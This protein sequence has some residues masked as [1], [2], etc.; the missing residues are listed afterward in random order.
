M[1]IANI[2]EFRKKAITYLKE[3]ESVLITRHGK[4]TGFLYPLKDV[5]TI[6]ENIQKEVSNILL[7]SKTD[8][9]KHSLLKGLKKVLKIKTVNVSDINALQKEWGFKGNMS[10]DVVAER[11][12]R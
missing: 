4:I 10:S 9:V 8:T 6:P 2:R 3:N 11:N 5:D 1:K 12:K 7:A